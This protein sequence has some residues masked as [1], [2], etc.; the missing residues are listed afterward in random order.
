VDKFTTHIS[1]RS[2]VGQITPKKILGMATDQQSQ[3]HVEQEFYNS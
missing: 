2:F 3:V 1:T